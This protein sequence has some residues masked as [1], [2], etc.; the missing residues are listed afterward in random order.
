MSNRLVKDVTATLNTLS[1]RSTQQPDRDGVVYGGYR[2]VVLD[3]NTTLMY[4]LDD[5]LNIGG[6]LKQTGGGGGEVTFFPLTSVQMNWIIQRDKAGG[7]I[8]R[9]I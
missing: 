1:L 7:F 8:D 9:N 2:S 5:N 3:E 6:G 4:Y